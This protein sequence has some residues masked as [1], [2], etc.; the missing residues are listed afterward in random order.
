[1]RSESIARAAASFA[2]AIARDPN[3]AQAHALLALARALPAAV[4][5]ASGS[6]NHDQAAAAALRAIALDSTIAESYQALGFVRLSRGENRDAERQFKRAI[7]LDSTLALGWAGFGLLANHIGDFAAARSRLGRARRVDAGL[8]EVDVWTAQVAFGEEKGSRA[9]AE[10]R[11]RTAT[12]SGSALSVATRVDALVASDRAAEAVALL[13]GVG[14]GDAA[15]AS[16]AR[17]LLAYASASAGDVERARELLLAMRDASAGAMP[18]MAT[19]AATLA[20]LGDLD[21]AV[22]VLTRAAARRDPTLVLF[23]RSG[24]FAALRKD[25]RGA[26]VFAGLERW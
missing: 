2:Q 25:S 1:L 8:R 14:A 6:Q 26:E 13:D 3:Y 21:S 23:G 22:G 20:A 10:S 15:V 18:P 24:R 19:L 17:A 5:A 4:D 12:D 7:A 11:L 9:E 16:D